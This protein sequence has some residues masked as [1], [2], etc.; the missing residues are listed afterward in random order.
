VRG[1]LGVAR[2]ARRRRRLW[3]RCAPLTM[4]ALVL[5]GTSLP[6]VVAMDA[7]GLTTRSWTDLLRW[8]RGRRVGLLGVA[9]ALLGRNSCAALLPCA[10]SHVTNAC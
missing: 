7:H 1:L 4:C 10:H 8:R 3:R 5:C 2:L 6:G 9:S